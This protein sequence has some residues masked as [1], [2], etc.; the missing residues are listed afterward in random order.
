MSRVRLG[1]VVQRIKD[2]VDKDN[3]DLIYYVGGEHFTNRAFKVTNKGLIKGSTIGPAFNTKFKSGDVL[4]MSRNPHLRKAGMVE[5]DGICSD[6]S[7]VIRTKDE[8]VLMQRFIPLLFQTDMFWEFAEKNKK[9]STN[10]FLNWKDFEQFEF[11]LPEMEKQIK[12]VE[13]LWSMVNTMDSYEEM[14]IKQDELI[15][16]QFIEM[17][18][19]LISNPKYKGIELGTICKT[20]SGGTPTTKH[21]EYYSGNI[22]W[23]TTVQL[24]ANYIDGSCAK[25]YITKEAIDNSATHLIP[26][27][28]ILFGTRVG[29]GK[30]SINTE[31][32]CTNQ[33]I[34]AIV[35]IDTKKWNLLFIKLVLDNYESHFDRI[36]KGATILGINTND[37]KNVMIPDVGKEMQNTYAI[38]VE[39]IDKSKFEIE[40]SLTELKMLFQKIVKEQLEN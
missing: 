12:L 21:P 32:M 13:M 26:A 18:G 19:D 7:Y 23:V 8:K 33:D 29:V 22:P 38:F 24:G 25:A 10:F 39:Q 37:L 11:E 5:F 34:N 3:T 14:L 40:K 4:L 17:F 31:P 35:N 20:I 2:P 27:N 9:G 30:S 36:K 28:N 6:V 15:K 1:D 16:S